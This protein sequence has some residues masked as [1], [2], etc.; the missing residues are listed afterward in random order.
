MNDTG[1]SWKQIGQDIDGKSSYDQSGWSVSISADG[2]LLPLALM[3]MMTMVIDQVMY[4]FSNNKSVL[5]VWAKAETEW[6]D[7]CILY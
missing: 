7:D 2:E 6:S 1:S 4:G 5:T 3:Q